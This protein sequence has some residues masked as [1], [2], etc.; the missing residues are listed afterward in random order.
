MFHSKLKMML[1]LQIAIHTAAGL[2]V[3]LDLMHCS[4]QLEEFLKYIPFWN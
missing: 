4:A 2:V 3:Y 1:R